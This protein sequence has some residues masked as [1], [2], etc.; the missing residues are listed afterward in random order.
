MCSQ[1]HTRRI[2]DGFGRK[3]RQH[4]GAVRRLAAAELDHASSISSRAARSTS[5]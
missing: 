2:A 5:T 4:H 1:G 3:Y